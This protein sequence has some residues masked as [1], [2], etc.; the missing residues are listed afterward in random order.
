MK[1]VYCTN[2]VCDLGGIELVTL[3]KANA[4]AKV[5]GN[6]VW[7][8]VTERVTTPLMELKNVKVVELGVNYYEDRGYRGFLYSIM[9]NFRRRRMHQKRLQDALNAIDPDIVI[10]TGMT[11]KLFLPTLRVRS[12]PVFVREMHLTRYTKTEHASSWRARLIGGV[13]GWYDYGWK[14]KAY[15]KIVVPTPAG[16]MDGW[17]TWDKVVVVP[18]PVMKKGNRVSDQSSQ[19]AITAGRLCE[20]KNFGALVRVWAKVVEK[21]PDWTLQIWGSGDQEDALTEQIERLGLKE[22]VCLMGYTSD[23]V[24]EMAK[25]S[26]FVLTSRTESFSLVTLEAMSVGLP[27]VVYNCPGGIRYVVEDGKTG[28]LVPM[29][30]EETFAEKVCALIDNREKRR[31]MGEEALKASEK[32]GIDQIVEQWMRLF[33]EWR[34]KKQ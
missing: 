27:A 10:A 16:K 7:V 9:E 12:N 15:D 1:I 24:G 11:E 8:M 32:Y 31:E 23:V 33:K 13:M 28:F 18:N 2:S 20:A 5:D 14:I 25:A 26:L 34:E 21:H 4:L 22:K 19:V 6:E 29:G 30:D 17:E 3:A